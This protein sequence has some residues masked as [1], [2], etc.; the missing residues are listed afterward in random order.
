MQTD[1]GRIN[2]V[3]CKGSFLRVDGS[4][5]IL[6]N[7][8]LHLKVNGHGV[9]V[10]LA[11]PF[12]HDNKHYQRLRHAGIPVDCVVRQPFPWLLRVL[13]K[14][15][16]VRSR[17]LESSKLDWERIGY[18]ASRFYFRTHRPDVVHLI[19]ADATAPGMIRAAHA[20]DVP[21]LYQEMITP[22]YGPSSD[23]L[24]DRLAKV[25]HLCASVTALSPAQANE[26]RE[27]IPYD[28]HVT[29]LPLISDDP[30]TDVPDT[31][32]EG[33]IFGFA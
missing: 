21:V 19:Q 22:R 7:Y 20:A 2:V 5:E 29:V 4:G 30:T 33:V 32:R 16:I 18:L 11:T 13:R 1:K 23:P 31:R 28:G 15:D 17:A 8:A 26:V 3:I 12:D 10:L 27:R 9:R 14:I 6:V 24:Y 25:L